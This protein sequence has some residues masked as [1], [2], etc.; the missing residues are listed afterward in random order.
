MEWCSTDMPSPAQPTSAR[1]IIG[2][3]YSDTINHRKC[4]S[5]M[6]LLQNSIILTRCSPYAVGRYYRPR[7]STHKTVQL[8]YRYFH[9]VF[10]LCLVKTVYALVTVIDIYTKHVKTV[11]MRYVFT[12]ARITALIGFQLLSLIFVNFLC[13]VLSDILSFWLNVMHLFSY[14]KCVIT[15]YS[16]GRIMLYITSVSPSV[17]LSVQVCS[18]G[19]KIFERGECRRRRRPSPENFWTFYLEIALFGAFWCV[20]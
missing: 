1:S 17:C 10:N 13:V 7:P 5:I 12:L 9:K 3:F 18:G 16:R 2:P 19:S 8:G 15:R 11:S 20:F 6:K 14:R 4:H